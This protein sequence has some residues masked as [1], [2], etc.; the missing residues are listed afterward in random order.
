MVYIAVRSKT[1]ILMRIQIVVNQV[2]CPPIIRLYR[3]FLFF[4]L[5]VMFSYYHVLIVVNFFKGCLHCFLVSSCLYSW[6]SLSRPRLSRI[7]SYLEVKILPLLKHENLTTGK[8]YCGKEEK[9]FLLFSHYF[10]YISNFK[11]PITYIFVKCG[12]SI[13]FVLNSANMICRG[14]D[15]S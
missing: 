10:Q 7:N 8:K 5:C 13:Y 11:S 2:L 1:N 3:C 6:L 12:C 4:F 15:I 9:Q 14:T